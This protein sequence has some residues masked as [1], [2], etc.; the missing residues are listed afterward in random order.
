MERPATLIV[1]G[2]P[3]GIATAASLMRRGLDSL[4]LEKGETVAPAWSH[5][6][7]RLHLHTNKQASGLPGRPMPPDYPKYPSRDQVF[8]YLQGY[9]R[10]EGV[11]VRFGTKVRDCRREDGVWLVST[12][13]GES[14]ESPHLVIA[15]SLSHVPRIPG[16][17]GQDEFAG[18]I[19]HTADYANGEPY[20]GKDVLV[21]GFGNS[22]GEI[23]L[24]L[25]EHG[26]RPR[27]SVRHPSV[28]VPR[29]I[30]GV[31]IL[32]I[33]RWMSVLPPRFADWISKPVLLATI[34]DLGK[35]GI[36]AADWGPMEQIAT[37]RKIPLLDVGTVA[38]LREGEIGARPG[39]ERFTESG[40][41]FTNGEEESFD[42]V[43]FGT[44]Y[45]T[46][47]E[48]ILGDTAGLLDDNGVPLV[49]GGVTS[50]PGLF[51]CGFREPPTGRLREIGLE[52][53]RIADLIA[54]GIGAPA[55]G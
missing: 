3:A 18:E 35:V 20:R 45:E 4:V 2:G 17:P 12:A 51:F 26:A 24:D 5:H 8:D 33:A 11:R 44:G 9:A 39:I 53:E 41:V 16:Y 36:P 30:A 14:F 48:S 34:G 21:V 42:A 6:Y 55:G 7:E 19:L 49:S 38:A 13:D 40:V 15:T 47:L 25:A 27:L 23:A 54:A 22:A 1:G 10:S 52:A 46:G 32:T 31:P 37:K 50:A 43:I 28:A 29:D